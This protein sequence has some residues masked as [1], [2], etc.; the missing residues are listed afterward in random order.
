MSKRLLLADDSITIQKVIGITFANED[1][2]LDIVD[3][4]DAAL[5]KARVDRPDLILAD[6]YMPGKN[7]YELCRAV[8]QDPG[9]QGVPVLLL[10]GTFEP[11]DEDKARQAGADDWISKPF[12][13]QALIDKVEELLATAAIPEAAPVAPSAAESIERPVVEPVREVF[14]PAEPASV[15]VEPIVELAEDDLWAEEDA[16]DLVEPDTPVAD[17]VSATDAGSEVSSVADDDVWGAVSFDEDELLTTPVEEVT[18]GLGAEAPQ[19]ETT[20]VDATDIW[21]DTEE[22]IF[23]LDDVDIIDEEDLLVDE[24]AVTA[25]PVSGFDQA[26]GAPDVQPA[27]PVAEPAAPVAEPAAPVAEPAAPVVEPAAPVAEPAAP[28]AEPAAPVAEPVAPVA[29]PVAPVAEPAAA[30]IEPTSVGDDTFQLSDD[31]PEQAP[32]VVEPVAPIS[33]DEFTAPVESSAAVVEDRVAALSDEQLEA[34]VEKV[35]SAVIER[36]AGTILEK[37]AWE[38]VPDLAENLIKEE[39]GKIKAAV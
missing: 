33:A 15:D 6:V 2:Q 39:I 1:F 11:F 30:S 16:F 28:V 20:A 26:F 22:E 34:I 4:G 3:N 29:E 10:T 13:S 31:L 25:E 17:I 32:E 37:V 35:A 9:L 21:Q 14:E 27:A 36:L 24:A 18:T 7:G 12:E 23:D 8:K 38:V 19:V 5:Q